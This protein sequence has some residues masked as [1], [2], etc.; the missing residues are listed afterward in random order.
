MSLSLMESYPILV[1]WN[2]LWRFYLRLAL[3]YFPTTSLLSTLFSV[4]FLSV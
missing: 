1:P 3:S 4:L 2:Y